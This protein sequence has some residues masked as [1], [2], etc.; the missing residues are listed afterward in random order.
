MK[1]FSGSA[2]KPLAEK[3]A[4]KLELKVS[5]LDVYVFP[6]GEKRVRVVDRVVDE[7]CI[8]V[9]PTNPPVDPNYME[10]F[11]IVDA[12]KRSGARSIVAVVPYLGYQ[13]QDH[14]FRD[15]E[16]VSLEVIIETLE[17]IGITGLITFDLH[18]VRIP[19]LFSIPVMHLS[20][21]PLFAQK[22]KE[23]SVNSE[24]LSI[25]SSVL[26]SPDMGGIARIKKLSEILDNMPYASIVKD[27][28]LVSGSVSSEKIEG[29][30]VSGKTAFIVDDMISSGGTIVA[31][32]E[33][34]QKKKASKIYVFAT[35]A[36]FS[37]DAP[38]VLQATNAE[39]I[40]VTDSIHVAEKKRFAKLEILSIS[41][42]IAEQ[43]KV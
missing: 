34:L 25:N 24:Q 14:I 19:D 26:V 29:T 6:D 7:D 23:L 18:S 16:A 32:C 43:L 2:N 38:E 4:K 5:S 28:D 36:V 17:S 20:A 40:Y 33:L 41:S 13:R 3:I 30:D 31:A 37:E 15:G 22:I 1:I 39:K 27:R 10:L 9:Q 12:L 21:L 11:F 8:V 42:M 35:H